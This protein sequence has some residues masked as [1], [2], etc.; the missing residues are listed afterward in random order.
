MSSARW[1]L[2]FRQRTVTLTH[3][4]LEELVA[5]RGSEPLRQ[6]LQDHLD[7]RARE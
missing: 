1:S 5:A 2:S 6:L 7:L 3:A 4:R